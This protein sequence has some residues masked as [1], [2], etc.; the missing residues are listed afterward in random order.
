[1]H[2]SSVLFVCFA[3]IAA[4][5]ADGH[6][7]GHGHGHDNAQYK[8]EYG[9]KDPHSHDMKEQHEHREGK[10]VKGGYSLSEPDGTHRIVKYISG[11]KSGFEAVVERKGHAKHPAVYG[12]HHIKGEGGTSYVGITHWGNQGKEEHHGDHGHHGKHEGTQQIMV[13]KNVAI[14]WAR[15]VG[16]FNDLQPKGTGSSVSD[17]Q[18]EQN[19]NSRLG[20][21]MSENEEENANGR[22][23][24]DQRKLD[25]VSKYDSYRAAQKD[26]KENNDGEIDNAENDE[27]GEYREENLEE[28]SN[29]EEDDSAKVNK[30]ENV[31][32][33]EAEEND[34][35]SG[36]KEEINNEND[37]EEIN[38]DSS[39][40]SDGKDNASYEDSEKEI[41]FKWPFGNKMYEE[42][43]GY[44][45]F[46][47]RN[48]F[49][50]FAKFGSLG[51]RT[52]FKS[53]SKFGC[54]E[55]G[56]GEYC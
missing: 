50:K 52:G 46:Y 39:E 20:S 9:I 35:D 17:E 8:F 18:E 48:G 19:D 21:Y 6:D 54:L 26:E 15:G 1:M 41:E 32:E 22:F 31:K 47:R 16:Y 43:K 42:Y 23:R 27:R 13:V 14:Q 30:S 55:L 2:F 36:E 38:D 25:D 45:D 24:S 4:V 37:N 3:I 51:D 49:G 33:V 11:P 28:A 10:H 7:D 29:E 5:W 40:E 53:G 56:H 44:D 12:K 34:E